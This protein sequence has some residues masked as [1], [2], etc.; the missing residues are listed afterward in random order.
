[1]LIVVVIN[2]GFA[3]VARTDELDRYIHGDHDV[4]TTIAVVGLGWLCVVV[5]VAVG[6][7]R[8]LYRARHGLPITELAVAGVA[9]T[10]QD[11]VWEADTELRFTYCGPQVSTQLGYQ[12]EQLL[13]RTVLSLLAPDDRTRMQRVLADALA[14]RAGWQN[15]EFSWRHSNGH[16]VALQGS[17]VPIVD[18]VGRLVGFRGARHP[19][20]TAMT[21]ERSLAAARH[22]IDV[23]LADT[24]LDIALQ[25]I[26]NASSGRLAGAEALARFRDGRRPYVWFTEA[27]ET[28]Q[29]LE[30]D[31]FAFFAGLDTMR[32][33]PADCYLSVNASPELI[34]DPDFAQR[35]IDANVALDRLVIEITEHVKI[36]CY[37]DIRA[38]LL[39]LRERGVRLAVDDTGAGYASFRHV[40]QLHPDIIKVDRSLIANIADD[41]ARRVLVT[42]LVLLARELGATVTAEGVET[43]TEL[44]TIT[45]LGVHTTQGY[46]LARPTIDRRRWK[47]WHHRTWQPGAQMA[48][49]IP[50]H[51]TSA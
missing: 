51:R 5:I 18:E 24:A 20:T 28:G 9:G 32:D 44:I 15:N 35:L 36:S 33:L 41:P 19:V 21:V 23:V 4:R 7:G 40:L 27:R 12:P 22:R 46:L 8:A 14:A 10:C 38:A 2:L 45:T 42:A 49:V 34:T 47:A 30:L 17:A 43:T 16:F 29:A 39:P 25:P 1:L 11:W 37:D 26:V 6:A 13:G 3:S 50:I 48:A 31:R